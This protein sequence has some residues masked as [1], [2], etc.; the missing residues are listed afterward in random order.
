MLPIVPTPRRELVAASTAAD[1]DRELRAQRTVALFRGV[2]VEAGASSGLLAR[3]HA[4]VATQDRDAIVAMQSAAVLHDLP[5]LP[6]AWRADCATFHLAVAPNATTR[7]RPGL[8]LH[9]RSFGPE[10]V[11]LVDGVPCMSA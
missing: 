8:R 7:H 1:I 6:D 9:R 2:H 10:D 4:A 11:V 3:A 5:W